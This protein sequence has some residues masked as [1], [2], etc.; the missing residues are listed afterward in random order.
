M[1]QIL[2]IF[3]VF[4]KLGLFT[5][6]GG[7][8]MIPHLKEQVVEKNKWLEEDEML[9]IIAI[10]ESTP[11]PIAINMA[12]YVGFKQKGILGS[13]AA[14][15]GVVLPSI[16]IIFSISLFFTNVLNNQYVGYAFVGIKCAVAFLILKTGLKMLIKMKKNAFNI[17]VFCICLIAMLLIELFSV[18][19]STIFLILFGGILGLII[20]S[21]SNRKKVMQPNF[22]N[23]IPEGSS[24]KE[25]E[26]K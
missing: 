5:F 26:I 22:D 13:I 6:G 1:L 4:F 24:Q 17:T 9:D 20:F 3:Y 16:I 8:A 11:G 14:T 7:Y 25:E 15:L 18:N 21:I 23:K 10:A 19:F 12:T 2:K